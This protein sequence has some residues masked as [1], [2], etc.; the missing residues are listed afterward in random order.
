[1]LVDSSGNPI[2]KDGSS[3]LI[4]EDGRPILNSND[5]FQPR[6]YANTV[7]FRRP[8]MHFMKYGCYTKAQVGTKPYHDYW[9][10]QTKRCLYGYRS[11]DLWITGKHYFYLN[12]L[13]IKKLPDWYYLKLHPRASATTKVVTFPDFWDVDLRYWYTKELMKQQAENGS[14]ICH[15]VLLKTRRIGC[16]FKEAGEGVW[17]YTFLKNLSSKY[18]AYS[19]DYLIKDGVFNKVGSMLNFINRYAHWGQNFITNNTFHKISGKKVNN[20]E[21]GRLNELIAIA[22]D[23]PEKGRGGDSIKVTYEEA[24]SFKN[25]LDSWIAMLPSVQ[26]GGTTTGFMTAFGTGNNNKNDGY[27]EGLEEMFYNPEAYKC[28]AFENIWDEGMEGTVCGFF[29]P[30][31]EIRTEYAD[32]DGNLDREAA[33]KQV[34]KERKDIEGT[35]GEAKYKIENPMCPAEALTRINNNLFDVEYAKRAKRR[36]ETDGRLDKLITCKMGGTFKEP[37]YIIVP[38]NKNYVEYPVKDE[39]NKESCCVISEPPFKDKTGKIPNN[40]YFATHDPYSK[41]EVTASQSIGSTYIVKRA[42]PYDNTGY[43]KLVAWYNGR[44]NKRLYYNQQLFLLISYYNATLQFEIDGGG[45]GIVEFARNPK[46]NLVHKL[47]TEPEM[48]FNKEIAGKNANKT[49]GVKLNV[50]NRATVFLEYLSD[51]LMTCIGLKEDGT[52][53]LFI[54]TI[55]DIGL[56]NEIIK[57]KE[58]MNADRLSAARLI[59]MMVRELES[60]AIK[61]AINKNSL[62]NR[63]LYGGKSNFDS[64]FGEDCLQDFKKSYIKQH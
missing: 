46:N 24:G 56:L 16:S 52:E 49:L 55:E 11:G 40:M 21:Y 61:K 60:V 12:F 48:L 27:I 17:N 37:T 38:A 45:Q 9:K 47:H 25:L 63:S 1:M 41:D 62:F 58:E 32:K 53:I 2:N 31:I 8:A 14:S 29:A 6:I 10:E 44:P 22:V 20:I 54:D 23:N 5:I 39:H 19:T 57:Y 28:I 42:N 51:M 26:Q 50:N 3:K 64:T 35:K 59:P 33:T 7:D 36:L 34:E 30:T 15:M 18:L 43:D 13:Q 4:R